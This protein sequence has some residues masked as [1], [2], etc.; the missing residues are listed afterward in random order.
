MHHLNTILILKGKLNCAIW[1]SKTCFYKCSL[2]PGGHGDGDTID[3]QRL[4]HLFL[5]TLAIGVCLARKGEHYL[6]TVAMYLLPTRAL[7]GSPAKYWA[8]AHELHL[9]QDNIGDFNFLVAPRG[10]NTTSSP[11]LTLTALLLAQLAPGLEVW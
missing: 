11:R 3:F 10:M 7:S 4:D 8:T 2:Y 5:V 6:A 9:H 1:S